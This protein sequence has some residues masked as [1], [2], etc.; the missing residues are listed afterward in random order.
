MLSCLPG[1]SLDRAPVWPA[2][3]RAV[4]APHMGVSRW[5]AR[6][7][8]ASAAMTVPVALS[9]V[10]SAVKPLAAGDRPCRGLA[11]RTPAARPARDD[12]ASASPHPAAALAAVCALAMAA[13]R[14]RA[15]A[16][17]PHGIVAKTV[18]GGRLRPLPVA[19]TA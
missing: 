19:G 13:S 15:G 6:R 1:S 10:S 14:A 7:D 3:G 18:S 17:D 16:D 2:Y 4:C 8:G 11:L 5:R 9:A 12:G